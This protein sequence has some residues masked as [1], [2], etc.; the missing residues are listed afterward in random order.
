LFVGVLFLLLAWVAGPALGKRAAPPTAQVVSGSG[1]FISPDG[2]V[3]TSAHG[4][5]GCATVLVWLHDGTSRTGRV[6]A[7]DSALDV[8]LLQVPGPATVYAR[9]PSDDEPQI[10]SPVFVL[11]YGVLVKNPRWP[12]SSEGTYVGTASLPY[13]VGIRVINAELQRGQSGGPVVDQGGALLGMVIGRYSDVPG[14]GVVLPTPEIDAFLAAHNMLLS[15]RLPEPK[16]ALQQML[17]AMTV[18]VQCQ[19]DSQ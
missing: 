8:A 17:R 16:A 5:A 2:N 13:S 18:L 15:K 9:A 14:R 6:I 3:V 10:G 11:G 7:S 1:F 12:V 19:P 4:I